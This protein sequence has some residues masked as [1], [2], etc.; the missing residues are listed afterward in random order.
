MHVDA[1][2]SKIVVLLPDGK[3]RVSIRGFRDLS[4]HLFTYSTIEKSIKGALR[5]SHIILLVEVESRGRV[6][7]WV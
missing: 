5:P 3:V 4:E 1:G 7:S 6:S 2:L